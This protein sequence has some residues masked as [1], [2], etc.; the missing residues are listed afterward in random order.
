MIVI[1]PGVAGLLVSRFDGTTILWVT[2]ATSFLAAVTTACP[3]AAGDRPE[4]RG[5]NAARGQRQTASSGRR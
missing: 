4:G 1:G 2:A 5:R 3:A